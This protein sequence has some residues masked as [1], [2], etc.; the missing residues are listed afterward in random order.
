M[1]TDVKTSLE[2]IR[3]E[4]YK[5]ERELDT[6]RRVNAAASSDMLA[7]LLRAKVKEQHTNE[8]AKIARIM[9]EAGYG[10]GFTEHYFAKRLKIKVCDA[11]DILSALCE[12]GFIEEYQATQSFWAYR[13]AMEAL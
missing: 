12:C 9:I 13:I 11:R 8:T 10:R 7:K 1:S 2:K 4:S 6:L 5:I 3:A